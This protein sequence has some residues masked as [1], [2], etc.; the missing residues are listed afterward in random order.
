MT[1]WG[2]IQI[3]LL[4]FQIFSKLRLNLLLAEQNGKKWADFFTT[5]EY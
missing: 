5:I 4:D 2:F 1:S 3:F